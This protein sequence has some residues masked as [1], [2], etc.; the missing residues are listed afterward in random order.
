MTHFASIEPLLI[1]PGDRMPLE[2]FLERWRQLPGLKFAELIDGVVY[3][4]STVSREHMSRDSRF[5]G[6]CAVYVYWTPGT[7]SGIN[8]TWRMTPSSAPQ[9]DCS[10]SILPEFGGRSTTREGLAAGVPEFVAEICYSSRAYDL[11]PKLALYQS[12]GVDEYLAILLEERRFEWRILVNGSYQILDDKAGVFRSRV[13]PGFW[14]D[15]N[16]YWN[17]DS[18]KLIQTLDQGLASQEHADFAARLQQARESKT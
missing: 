18:K 12:A 1:R 6:L 14:I 7:E 2:E 3:M 8:G 5:Q 15:S 10:L 9:P 4:P 11:G 16:A 13:L 17:G